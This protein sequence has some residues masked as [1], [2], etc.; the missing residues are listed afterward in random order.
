MNKTNNI[1][2]TYRNFEMEILA[3]DSNM[4]TELV[5]H[6]KQSPL[7]IYINKFNREKM[8]AGSNLIFQKSI[9]IRDFKLNIVD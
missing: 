1:D 7:D 3:G 9:G 6:Y 4:I 2:N 5:S 8:N